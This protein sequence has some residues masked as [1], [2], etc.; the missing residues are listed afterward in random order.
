VTEKVERIWEDSLWL[1]L[2]GRSYTAWGLAK[3]Y[4]W[5]GKGFRC[6]ILSL[7]SKDKCLICLFSQFNGSY[8][9]NFMYCFYFHGFHK[10]SYDFIFVLRATDKKCAICAL[11]VIYVHISVLYL[12]C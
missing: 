8:M 11:K 4:I 3:V 9:N 12:S 10:L 2:K 6:D 5:W 7:K 1:E